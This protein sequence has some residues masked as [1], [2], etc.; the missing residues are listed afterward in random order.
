MKRNKIG[1]VCLSALCVFGLVGGLSSCNETTPVDPVDPVDP[2]DPVDPTPDGH[3]DMWTDEQKNLMKKY[4][5]EVLPY[6]VDLFKGEVVVQEVTNY[7]YDYTYLEIYDHA[8]SFTLEDY[9]LSLEDFGWKAV[10]DYN[11]NEVQIDS[12]GT[13]F[14]E[15]TK[16]SE[17]KSKAYDIMY[18][19]QEE[20]YDEDGNVF[21][22]NVIH[23]YNDLDGK[24][25]D[26]TSWSEEEKTTFTDCLGSEVPFIA[27]GEQ[28][29]VYRD[30]Y[31]A[32]VVQDIYY[33]NLSSTYANILVNNG[34]VLNTSL[35]ATYGNY[36]LSKT[37]T[38]GSLLQVVIYYENGNNIYFYY[39]PIETTHSSWP[40]DIV[41]E[42]KAKSGVEI[43]Q[44]GKASDG[45]YVTFKIGETYF[46]KTEDLDDEFDYSEYDS[47]QLNWVGLNWNETL[48]INSGNIIDED[49][50]PVGYMV[51]VKPTTPTSSFFT[52]W[53]EAKLKEG[54]SSLLNISDV[55]IPSLPDD[56]LPNPD[57]KVKYA[58]DESSIEIAI[59]DTNL[60]VQTEFTN[61]LEKAGWFIGYNEWDETYIED[62]D[63]KVCISISG[64]GDYSH[65]LEGPTYITF[66]AGSG[67]THEPVFEF[68][69][70]EVTAYI[71]HTCELELTKSMLPYDVT[72][73]TSEDTSNGK[74]TVDEEGVVTV[75]EDATVGS[76]IKVTASLTKD[77]GSTLETSCVVT[78]DE[79]LA[80]DHDKA[81]DVLV[82]ALS[83]KGFSDVNVNEIRDDDDYFEKYILTCNFGTT[84][85][86]ED[87]KALVKSD[88]IP[89]GFKVLQEDNEEGERVDT[90]WVETTYSDPDWNEYQ[91]QNIGYS[92]DNP[93]AAYDIG[94]Y[95]SS[96]LLDYYVYQNEG[97]TYLVVEIK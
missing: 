16:A 53:P 9:Y 67:E 50:E 58:E 87:V 43:P 40:T 90:D 30:N 88:L 82:S 41:N 23:C 39:S 32:V 63:G 26:A 12:Y 42:I 3:Y 35:S 36:I 86:V 94:I 45:S 83:A 17:D 81:K 31:N 68:E 57:Y 5:G 33:E 96:I 51:Q 25:T 6:P 56:K 48:E 21:S 79:L 13:G 78:T 64:Y 93:D 22:A 44:F 10:R 7:Y 65:D 24:K 89:N 91:A 95:D 59:Y 60:A 28:T 85:T 71:G 52:S 54:L 80:Y 19:Y 72:Y 49:Y 1:I 2:P 38:D 8:T 70:S 29:S 47:N 55:T 66:T 97:N 77:D 15:I 11:E 73:T 62:P 46:I 84:S 69:N 27:L 61:L 14:V 18:S 34:F 75:A 4:C 76:S 92:F 74:I 37:F 20:N